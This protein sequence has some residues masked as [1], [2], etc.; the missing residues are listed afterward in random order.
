VQL[1]AGSPAEGL[2]FLARNTRSVEDL[3]AES[4]ATDHVRLHGGRLARLP[5]TRREALA[6]ASF[7]KE[8]QGE[9][10]VLLGEEATVANLRASAAGKRIIHLATHGL[11]GS[12][13]R[14]YDA[15]LALARPQEVGPE[16][17]GFLRLEDLIRS[18][19][20][21]LESAEVAVL[22][23]CSTERGV[24]KGESV[25]ALPWGF[26]F[27]GAST[28]VSSLWEVDDEATALLM[29]RFYQN[30][31]GTHPGE[32][33]RDRQGAEAAL[34]EARKWLRSLSR[35]EAAAARQELATRVTLGEELARGKDGAARGPGGTVKAPSA[36][37]PNEER[38]YAHPYYWGAFICVGSPE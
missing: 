18:W 13:D 26:L 23:A 12:L 15:S 11:S 36:G 25:L 1:A 35:K 27:A 32:S 8:T 28:V 14:P 6:I 5:G 2:K 29:M 38:P 30:L 21:T 17:M 10:T 31:L 37:P 4:S 3:T 33:R 24:A 7:I 34:R 20:G 9:S 19:R 16:D 22:S